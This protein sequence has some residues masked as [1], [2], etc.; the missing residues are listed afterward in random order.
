MKKMTFLF[1]LV[2]FIQINHAQQ[3]DG[4][5]LVIIVENVL[6]DDGEIL[7]ALHTADTFMRTNGIADVMMQA[8]KG[9]VSFT[10]KD[11]K[12][13]KYAVMVMHDMNSN[14][15]MDFDS[16]GMPKES[17]GMSG[18]EMQMGPPTFDA[19]KFEVADKDLEISIRF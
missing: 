18:S 16:S 6:S 11:V 15:N 8:K 3:T 13:G 12:P 5:E 9:P 2:F 14:Q 19:A 4:V 10:F 17:Y 1:A 7:A